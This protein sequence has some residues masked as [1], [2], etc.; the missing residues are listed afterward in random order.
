[1]KLEDIR[2]E[3]IAAAVAIIFSLGSIFYYIVSIEKDVERISIDTVHQEEKILMINNNIG[4]N[5]DHIRI[6]DKNVSVRIAEIDSK[7]T[8]IQRHIS[9]SSEDIRKLL[10]TILNKVERQGNE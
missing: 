9:G 8:A 6:V 7:V 4:K 5:K 1:M 10:E 3:A 2:W